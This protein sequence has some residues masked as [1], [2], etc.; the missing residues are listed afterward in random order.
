MSSQPLKLGNFAQDTIRVQ[1]TCYGTRLGN[2]KVVFH[3]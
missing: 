2:I 1:A 3:L